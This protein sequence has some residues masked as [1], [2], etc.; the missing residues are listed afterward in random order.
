[1]T[2]IEVAKRIIRQGNCD[3]LF[4]EDC[5]Q[6]PAGGTYR[7]VGCT[8]RKGGTFPG[9]GVQYFR[10]W[11]AKNEKPIIGWPGNVEE[12]RQYEGQFFLFSNEISF[13]SP[14]LGQMFIANYGDRPYTAPGFKDTYRYCRMM[15]APTFP[16]LTLS[17]I[18]DKFGIPLDQLRI[19]DGTK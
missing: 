11:L 15:P 9:C 4:A 8:A 13:A 3:G 2:K 19:K 17:E 6:C 7:G 16:E 10:D 5:I 12:M 1:M 14:G 18:A